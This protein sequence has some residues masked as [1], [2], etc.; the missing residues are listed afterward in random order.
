[1][2]D[3][4]S[5][6][7]KYDPKSA[8]EGLIYFITCDKCNEIIFEP[9]ECISCGKKF[10]LKH[11]NDEN[12]NINN[13]CEDDGLF[14]CGSPKFIK[15]KL[16]EK[17]LEKVKFKCQLDYEGNL[18]L[19][20]SELKSHYEECR[21]KSEEI[22]EHLYRIKTGKNNNINNQSLDS[23]ESK[24]K[25]L[26]SSSKIFHTERKKLIPDSNENIISE[27]E[28]NI[29]FNNYNNI[30]Y[31]FK[32]YHEH[33]LYLKTERKWDW[34]CNKCKK[35]FERNSICRFRCNEC[36]YDICELCMIYYEN[37]SPIEFFLSNY[38]KNIGWEKRKHIIT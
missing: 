19:S 33:P 7:F 25:D 30:S 37:I 23:L 3:I 14:C 27:N 35:K 2:T 13:D 28:I 24:L 6:I 18:L 32:K 5:I 26:I 29:N 15:S 12:N 36:N 22:E 31:T 11:F 9:I 10:C 4:E 16:L 38:N 17:G 20:H 1:M 8:T 21:K 34:K